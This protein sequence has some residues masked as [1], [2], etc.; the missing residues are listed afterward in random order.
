[1]VSFSHLDPG[2]DEQSWGQEPRMSALAPLDLAIDDL[3][4]VAAHPDDETLG[5]AGL[6]QAVHRRGGR[7]TVI[8]AT[9]GEG[10]HPDSPT[11]TPARLADIR[12]REVAAAID[13]LAPGAEVRF[14]GLPDGLLRARR[15]ELTTALSQ[16]VDALDIAA[17]KR[18]AALVVAPWSGDGHPDHSAAAE[19]SARIC[20]A[21]G[22]AHLGYPI[23]L[24][25]WGSGDDVPWVDAVRHALTRGELAGKRRAI[26]THVSQIA[27]LSPATGDEPIVHDAMRAHF[28]RPIEVFMRE[29]PAHLSASMTGEWFEDFY[30]RN[31]DP[32]GFETRWYEE[33]KRSLL[34][35]SLPPKSLGAVLELGCSTGLITRELARRASSVV[36]LDPAQSA[37][38][39]A[40]SR[41]VGV[42]TVELVR[43]RAPHDWPAGSYDTIVMSEVGYYLDEHDLDE[44]IRLIERDLTDDGCLVAC[45]WRH[46]VAEYPQTGDDVHA[47]LRAAARWEP[48]V[49]HHER[50]FL[51]EVFCPAPA[52]SVA[53]REGLA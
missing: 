8:V 25:H 9:D 18:S 1:M 53:E 47:A 11:H 36:A 6:M 2:A 51:L 31:A 12:R 21:R 32:W 50:D 48:I 27:P 28:E 23:W 44:T 46:P 26:A 38:D 43:G 20:A 52:L 42:D 19:A 45:H 3:V 30:R 22:I 49:R 10:S 17:P 41:L 24:W 13:G 29:T 40:R 7:V 4:V 39:T 34:M 37:L 33:R 14:L 35:A 15:D 16:T 5:A